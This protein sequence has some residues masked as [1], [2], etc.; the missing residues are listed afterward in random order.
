MRII[1]LL[2]FILLFG[3]NNQEK[4]NQLEEQA[5]EQI[6]DLNIEGAISTYK[7]ILSID[8]SS[9]KFVNQKILNDLVIYQQHDFIIRAF[10]S[11]DPIE[12]SLLKN[13]NL[14]KT[15]ISFENLDS[16]IKEELYSQLIKT[17]KAFENSI[18]KFLRTDCN[19]KFKTNGNTRHPKVFH[20]GVIGY[21]FSS[22]LNEKNEIIKTI[23]EIDLYEEVGPNLYGTKGKKM[24]SKIPI[25]IVGQSHKSGLLDAITL[26]NPYDTI[27]I[28]SKNFKRTDFW[29]CPLEKAV[30]F[31]DVPA[32]VIKEEPNPIG[33]RGK[34]QKVKKGTKVFCESINRD[35]LIVC[36]ALQKKGNKLLFKR[37]NGDKLLFDKTTLK[38]I[39]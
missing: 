39:Y 10:E 7:E 17:P 28:I 24:D 20:T 6:Q 33:W 16:I 1:Q 31:G 12:L 2:L 34:W 13:K 29:N 21:T 26:D 11:L 22:Y 8:N 30:N 14:D 9:L 38:G 25:K 23:P 27:V 15:F 3:C 19:K 32:I 35:G 37:N 4:I 18:N 5:K 36:Y